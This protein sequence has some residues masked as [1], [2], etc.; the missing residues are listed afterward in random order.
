MTTHL[1]EIY[2]GYISLDVH[3]ESIAVSIAHAGRVMSE[4]GGDIANK[5]KTVAKLIE[6]LSEAFNS[7][8]YSAMK[9]VPA[10]KDYIG[11]G[12]RNAPMRYFSQYTHISIHRH[13]LPGRVLIRHTCQ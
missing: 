9:R 2:P 4:S 6:Q 8:C 7:V 13:K 11:I 10:A 12:Q 3:K 5:P 1:S